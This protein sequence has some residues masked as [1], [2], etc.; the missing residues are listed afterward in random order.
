MSNITRILLVDDHLLFREG[1]KRI[2]DHEPFFEVVGVG[3]DGNEAISLVESL[4]PDLVIMD[5]N[6]PNLN[7][8]DAVKK[9]VP[10]NPKAKVLMLSSST[11]ESNVIDSLKSGASGYLW[12]GMSSSELIDAIKIVIKCGHYLHPNVTGVVIKEMVENKGRFKENEHITPLHILTRREI[13]VLQ[14]LAQGCSNRTIAKKLVISENTV[15]NHIS[16]IIEKMQ[17]QDR[18]QAVLFAISKN[19]VMVHKEEDH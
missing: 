5:I 14:L 10:F 17:V 13:D 8:I 11:G 1:V 19:W 3:K 2:L 6:M 9:I 16:N 7:G 4:N 12:K 15:K 18:T